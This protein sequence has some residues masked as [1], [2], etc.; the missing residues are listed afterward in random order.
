MKR[1]YHKHGMTGTRTYAVWQD[2]HQ[3]C[4][5]QNNDW[6]SHYGARGILVCERWKKFTNFYADMGDKPKSKSLDRI[7]NN[8]N[9]EPSNCRW[10]TPQEQNLNHR[11]IHWVN[12]CG[13]KLPLK[14]ATK[15]AGLHYTTVC[16]RLRQGWTEHEALST[17]PR[18]RA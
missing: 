5:N 18:H 2:M 4:Y 13:E 9:Y 7:N 17:P 1:A 8:G 11:R 6:Y 12:W 3:R 14:V 16:E 15:L 10:A